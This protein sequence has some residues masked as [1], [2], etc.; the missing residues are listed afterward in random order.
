LT[1]RGAAGAGKSFII[2]IIVSYLSQMSH[3][4]DMVHVLAP[5]DMAAFY[6]LGE[7]LLDWIG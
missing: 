7:T 4:N 5:T 3:D 2:I 1:I 6:V